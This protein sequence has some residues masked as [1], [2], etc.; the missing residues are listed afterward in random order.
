MKR[1]LLL[2]L[3]TTAYLGFSQESE[4]VPIRGKVVVDNNDLEGITV[5]NTSSN[6]GT[7]TNENGEFRIQAMLNDKIE[8]AALQFKDFTV[9]ID[10]TIIKTGQMTVY[11]VEQVNKLD[12]VLILP[13]DLTGNLNADIESIR[14][15]NPDMDALAFGVRNSNEYQFAD[16]NRSKVRNTAMPDSSHPVIVNGLNVINV[17]K[18]MIS[19]LLKQDLEFRETNTIELTDDN[20]L[21][22]FY[23]ISF[24][25]TN[26]DIPPDRVDEFIEYAENNG[27]R[28]R[29]VDW[30]NELELLQFLYEKRDEFIKENGKKD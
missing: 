7:I 5:F 3:L 6:R 29:M 24:I 2:L 23:S 4:R 22:D 28:E 12:E 13:Y 14:T 18:L 30:D 19:P 20:D 21:E 1:I 25:S 9:T 16:D 15:F 26:F 8:F 11:L 27:L 17:V 10:E